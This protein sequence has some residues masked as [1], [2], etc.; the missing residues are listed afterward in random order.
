[1]EKLVENP[2]HRPALSCRCCA[3]PLSLLLADLGET[4]IANDFLT[5]E[6]LMRPEPRLPLRAYVCSSCR[7][8]QLEDFVMPN[9]VFA[10]D[11]AYQSS[12][13]DSWLAHAK[14]FSTKM[15]QSLALGP[16]SRVV[17]IASNDGYLLQYFKS[18]NIPVTG[19]EPANHVAC[20]AREQRHIPTLELFFGEATGQG[21]AAQ[22]GKADLIIANNVLA[23]VPDPNDFIAGFR[24]LL[25]DDGTATFEFPHLLS[26]LNNRQFDTIYHEHFS[27]LSLL[28]L[29]PAFARA[30]LKI[31]DAE[32]LPTHGGS[33]RIYVAH[34]KARRRGTERLQSIRGKEHAAGLDTDIPYLAFAESIVQLK[35]ELLHLLSGIKAQGNIIAA[36]GAPAKGNTLLN[37]CGIGTNLIDFTVDRAP[38]KQGKFLPGSRIPILKPEAISERRPDYILILPWNLEHEITQQLGFIRQ[39]GGKFI[40]P[41][42]TPGIIGG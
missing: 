9:D 2:M 39:W 6:D 42:P 29:D 3:A 22:I 11:Y 4:P 35:T 31:F 40:R 21:L 1:M 16:D 20:I 12:M 7:L 5:S 38:S 36:Y 25:K 37:Y 23:H 33:L 18:E 27:Y 13:S 28:S 19:V 24:E 10:A 32:E 30:D 17:E 14:D 8:V 26:L 41:I 34:E 15:I